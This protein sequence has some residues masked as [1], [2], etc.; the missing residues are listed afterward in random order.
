MSFNAGSIDAKLTLDRSSWSK[1]LKKTIEEADKLEQRTITIGIDADSDN[2]F[3]H[4]ESVDSWADKLDERTVTI[5]IEAQVA[6]L[7]AELE[8]L[9]ARLDR[10]DSRRVTV[11]IDADTDN[12]AVGI[13][14]LET[15]IITLTDETLWI[16]VKAN[17]SEAVAEFLA[18]EQLGEDIGTVNLNIEVNKAQVIEQLAEVDAVVKAAST[19]VDIPVD[20]NT[21]DIYAQFPELNADIDAFEAASKV[22]IPVDVD[23]TAEAIA[24]LEL[25]ERKAKDVDHTR[26]NILVD[27][28]SGLFED[29]GAGGQMGLLKIL[30]I[31]LIF[32]SPILAVAIGALTAAVVGFVGALVAAAGPLLLLVGGIALLVK[33]YTDAKK[34][35]DKMVGPM[36]DFA[37]A[38][39]V[40]QDA[41]DKVRDSIGKAGFGLMA[42]GLE[43]A[44]KILPYLVPIFNAAAHAISGVLDIMDGFVDSPGMKSMMRFFGH[45]GLKMLMDFIKILG[46]LGLFFGRLF[47]AMEP[48]IRKMMK[49]LVD[50]T[51]SWADWAA[52]LENNK[53]FQDWLDSAAKYGPQVLDMLGSLLDGLINIGK[54]LA[55]FAGP[56]LSILTKFFDLIANM[57][58]GTLGILIVSFISLWAGISFILP[59]IGALVEGFTGF[60]AVITFLISPIGLII[61]A[62]VALAAIIYYLWK[63]N[64]EFHAAVLSV[65]A[66]IKDTVIPIARD[67]IAYFKE[68][69]PEIKKA[70]IDTFQSI[71]GIISD[72]L[73]I[74][75]VIIKA[76][77]NAIRIFW[78][79]FGSDIL[80]ATTGIFKTIYNIISGTL[81]I[82]GGIIK[83]FKGAFT[84]DW[85]EMFKG[86]KMIVQ[87]GK[88]MLS[89]LFNGIKDAI[90]GIIT[91]IADGIVNGIKGAINT[92]I[93]AWNGLS[94]SIP[95]FDPPGP[96]PKFGG[97]TLHVPTI[98]HVAKGG[99]AY[100]PTLAVVGD[101]P[102]PDPEVIQ[103][104]SDLKALLASQTNPGIDYNMLA[105][106]LTTAFTQALSENGGPAGGGVSP[107]DLERLIRAASVNVQINAQDAGGSLRDFV[108]ELMFQFR[109]RG[110]GGL[111]VAGGY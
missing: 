49:G 57:D 93:D 53:A 25:L 72:V 36:A 87:G 7:N 66:S 21:N 74:V 90:L 105:S 37:D 76:S 65:W 32:L 92:V 17:T 101:N 78:H 100:D 41:L 98:P 11:M 24:E 35:G 46:N 1:E 60:V 68:N 107:E 26:V 23:G 103:P 95:G 34:A 51:G 50:L 18:L 42:Q 10:L 110:Y 45:F 43:L 62:I 56:M 16:D 44:A 47:V 52:N 29:S 104:L 82:V 89:G 9:E 111:A 99:L 61:L 70:T 31:S 67:I 69:W 2:F 39:G 97:F 64:D 81:K 22:D 19:Q 94:F 48:F 15:H 91:K 54:A 58:T 59:L 55:P 63:T 83:V 40:F 73:I 75:G 108:T 13:D 88:Q 33:Q 8:E 85:S 106:T 6:E 27:S 14:N 102:G 77:L 86:L 4:Y 20:L 84:G 3:Q 96:G 28:L 80:K 38:L 79:L 30:I 12:A 71:A 109:R 5:G